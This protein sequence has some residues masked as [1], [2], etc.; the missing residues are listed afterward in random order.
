M[1]CLHTWGNVVLVHQFI[2]YKYLSNPFSH[3]NDYTGHFIENEADIEMLNSVLGMHSK[4]MAEMRLK[5]WTLDCWSFWPLEGQN[6]LIWGF[7]LP[8][9]VSFYCSCFPYSRHHTWLWGH[10]QS[11][12]RWSGLMR[13]DTLCTLRKA[14][15]LLESCC[16][17][18]GAV[19]SKERDWQWM[20]DRA[21]LTANTQAEPFSLAPL[22]TR[23]EAAFPGLP[24]S[25]S[26]SL[27]PLSPLP[28][29]LDW[30]EATESAHSYFE[31]SSGSLLWSPLIEFF[32]SNLVEYT[33]PKGHLD[34]KIW[35]WAR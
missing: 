3:L 8:L 9:Y 32:V 10:C 29:P 20:I 27:N 23:A 12:I 34:F 31:L 18:M 26:P 14:F 7:S 21:E 2:V 13:V 24:V 4:K 17:V 15:K 6:L 25:L 28:H 11:S 33:V 30:T 19:W 16:D 5:C 22:I 35:R 1:S